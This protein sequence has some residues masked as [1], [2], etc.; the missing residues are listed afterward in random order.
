MAEVLDRDQMTDEE[1]DEERRRRAEELAAP[2]RLSRVG[3]P[4]APERKPMP[5]EDPE[6]AARRL[7]PVGEQAT[8]TL[9]GEQQRLP[10]LGYQERQRLPII[11]PGAPAGSANS[12]EAQISR[13]EDQRAHPWGSPE[14]HPGR[15][16]KIGHVLG[17]IGN[18]A[19]DVLLPEQMAMIPGTDLNRDL[20]ERRAERNLG[21]AQTRES[22]TAERGARTAEI[23]SATKAREDKNEQTLEKDAQGNVT[24]WKDK[25]GALHS[26]EEEGTPQ[27]IKDIAAETTSKMVPRFEKDENGNIVALKTD[28]DGKTTSEVVYKGDPKLETD[29]VHGHII[30]GV[31]HT[32]LVNKKTGETI[33]DLGAEKMP[34]AAAEKEHGIETVLAY[35]K[36]NKPH[37]MS[38]ADAEAEGMTHIMKASDK[39]VNDAKTHTVTLNDMQA[40]L[41]DVVA[42]RKALDQDTAQ[43]VI[44]ARALRSID[45]YKTL[46]Q[47]ADAGILAGSTPQSQ[48]YIQS[49]LSL[50]ESALGLPKEIT[51]GS[52]VSE[53][54]ASALWG[55]LPGGASLNG[56]YALKQGKKFQANIDRLRERAPEVRGVHIEDPHP[57]VATE[58]KAG[59][60]GG[61]VKI[62]GKEYKLGEDDTFMVGDQKYKL[63]ADRKTAAI[64][65]G[66]P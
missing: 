22:E 9:G 65:T 57:D 24:G 37:L 49:I 41:N 7:R 45:K 48:E 6:L 35:D 38:K 43:R 64:V 63:N 16:G 46:G 47:L 60:A 42:S 13:I 58:K 31:P 25:A 59:A 15:L 10:T 18:V 4:I 14:N 40:K 32:L 56:D 33:K 2:T 53:I 20:E 17:Q 27:A 3:A 29:L 12:Y 36:N 30:A 8:S 50:R 39:D 21:A 55:T 66:K 11:S 26:L 28:R 23:Q 19:G 61:T 34:S 44:I 1:L 5:E 52:R 54:Q 62:G 51:G